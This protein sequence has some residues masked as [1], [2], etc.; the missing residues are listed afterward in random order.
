MK[1]SKGVKKKGSGSKHN[2]SKAKDEPLGKLIRIRSDDRR[3]TKGGDQ[4]A[5]NESNFSS[6]SNRTSNVD[7]F[8]QTQP[9]R[10]VGPQVI[11]V[12]SKQLQRDQANDTLIESNVVSRD[13]NQSDEELI[14]S[15]IGDTGR[16][17]RRIKATLDTG[18]NIDLVT[19]VAEKNQG[20]LTKGSKLTGRTRTYHPGQINKLGENRPFFDV[21][22]RTTKRLENSSSFETLVLAISRKQN[23]SS[24]LKRS[25]NFL[26]RPISGANQR[27]K[28]IKLTAMGYTVSTCISLSMAIRSN[29]INDHY[30]G[31]KRDSILDFQSNRFN[32]SIKTGTVILNDEIIP[33][34]NSDGEEK[35]F[36][37]QTRYQSTIEITIT[38]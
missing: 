38:V 18:T 16:K 6:G 8:I 34:E 14:Q 20:T 11:P 28:K 30:K 21:S 19:T 2:G 37:Y 4:N 9:N 17:P 29:L 35:D 25:L 3:R 23:F 36:I 32:Q 27:R 33:T 26:R 13:Y 12:E 22:E 10:R 24:L 5:G 1:G 31:Y 7:R 15:L